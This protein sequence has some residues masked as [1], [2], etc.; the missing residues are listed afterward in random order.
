MVVVVADME[1]ENGYWLA[2]IRWW[3]MV[4][5]VVQGMNIR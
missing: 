3:V 5:T 2:S 4:K 1:F